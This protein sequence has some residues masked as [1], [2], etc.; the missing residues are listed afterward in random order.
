MAANP[1]TS[2]M[3]VK[4]AN[5]QDSKRGGVY[6]YE[7]VGNKID[8]NEEWERVY[9]HLED[10]GDFGTSVSRLVTLV[11]IL[12]IPATVTVLAHIL[13]NDWS[14]SSVHSS[15]LLIE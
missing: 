1:T 7:R 14:N 11:L 6:L 13:L 8:N 15:C 4:G 9:Q 2:M 3:L 10:S 12:K 5:R